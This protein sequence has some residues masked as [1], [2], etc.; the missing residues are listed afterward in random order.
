[1]QVVAAQRVSERRKN[2]QA[3][4]LQE[5]LHALRARQFTRAE[6]I[7]AS[8]LRTSKTDRAALLVHA[9]SAARVRMA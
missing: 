3:Q 8:I 6:Q 7:A 2:L 9:H 5:A 1:L 4:A